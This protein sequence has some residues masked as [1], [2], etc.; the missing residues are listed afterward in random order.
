MIRHA[1]VA[2]FD[3][4]Y[5]L[6][7]H[8]VVNPWLLYEVMDALH[9]RPIFDELLQK[10]VLYVYEQEDLPAGM[11][12]LVPQQYRNAHILYIG[13]IGIHPSFAGKGHGLRLMEEIKL[14][15]DAE[16]YQRLELSV[17]TINEKA[18]RIYER[19]G[20]SKE[21]IMKNFTF[22]KSENR[23]LDEQLMSFLL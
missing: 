15:A 6:Y 2:D 16:G 3:F 9:F 7:M 18:I 8:P 17:A 12:K 13:G 20:F 10:H 23:F 1:S 19:A 11:C 21:G 5:E 4:T 14:F 22:L